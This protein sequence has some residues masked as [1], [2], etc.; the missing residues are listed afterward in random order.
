MG[1]FDRF[2]FYT[3]TEI[4]TTCS[5]LTGQRSKKEPRKKLRGSCY[6]TDTRQHAR[7]G[8]ARSMIMI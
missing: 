3:K 8:A 4:N 6:K 5:D 7:G 1:K 2:E